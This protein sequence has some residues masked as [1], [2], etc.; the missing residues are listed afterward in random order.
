MSTTP[1]PDIEDRAVPP[2]P[3][4][5]TQ[6]APRGL[7]TTAIACGI[8]VLGMV[9]LSFA[10]VPLYRLFCQAT[11]FAGTPRIGTAPSTAQAD[12]EVMVRFDANV[13]PGV[14]WSFT[15]E[16][17]EVA[18]AL[19]ETKTVF[20]RI[21][22]R[23]KVP[24]TGIATFNVQPEQAG[25]YFVKIQCF[26]FNEQTLAPGESID[27]PVVFY[28]DPELAKDRDL[29]TLSTITLSYTVFPA[30]DGRPMAATEG[31]ADKPKL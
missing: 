9:G 27:A 8:T 20:Y 14:A 21:S 17:T 30:K 6:G 31:A 2:G 22:N 7:R 12:R 3:A 10:A 29:K 16:Q 4:A 19:G 5:P 24:T 15:P 26:C 23:A 1:D 11:G 28:V 25:A 13:A 18:A